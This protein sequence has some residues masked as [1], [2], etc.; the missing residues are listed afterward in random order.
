MHR[1]TSVAMIALLGGFVLIGTVV[2]RQVEA[3]REQSQ[4]MRA[5]V[6]SYWSE[7]DCALFYRHG[8]LI[9]PRL[10]GG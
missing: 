6:T 2:W 3:S 7:Q 5:C 10:R 9:P 8:Q 1:V 4:F